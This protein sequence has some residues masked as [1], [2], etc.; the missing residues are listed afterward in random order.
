MKIH[1]KIGPKMFDTKNYSFNTILGC[2][3][4]SIEKCL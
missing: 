1:Y 3:L 2:A 4:A